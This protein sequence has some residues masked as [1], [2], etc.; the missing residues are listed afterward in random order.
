MNDD[1]DGSSDRLVAQDL[2][3]GDI[4]IVRDLGQIRMADDDQQV[5]IRL[6]AVLPI[7]DPIFARIA[8]EQ[9]DLVDF[10]VPP[11]WLSRPSDR[12]L[13]L[14]HQDLHDERELVLLHLRK[15]IDVRS[16]ECFV[17]VSHS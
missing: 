5:E 7:I 13:E 17:P 10:A 8:A 6:V 4:P 11:R 16:H 15:M 2:I 14:S 3:L 1:V 12:Q 9:D